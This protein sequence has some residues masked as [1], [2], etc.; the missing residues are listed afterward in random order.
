MKKIIKTFFLLFL[1][2]IL[3]LVKAFSQ[4]SIKLPNPQDK[5]ILVQTENFTIYSSASEQVAKNLG[6]KLERLKKTLTLL[7]SVK[8]V[9]SP[10]PTW[11][12]IFKDNKSFTPYIFDVYGKT[13]ELEGYFITH[14][15]GNYIAISAKN[16]GMRTIL[17]EYIHFFINNNMPEVPLWFNEGFAEYYSTFQSDGNFAQIGLPIRGHVEY[18]QSSSLMSLNELFS[19][20]QGSIFYSEETTQNIF[21]AQSWLLVHYLLRGK[22]G[23]LKP[24]LNQFLTRLKRGQSSDDAFQESFK[25]DYGSLLKDL[26]FYLRKGAFKYIRVSSTEISISPNVQIRP[27]AYEEVL[28]NLGDLVMHHRSK[29]IAEAEVHYQQAISLNPK[30]GLAFAGLGSIKLEQNNFQEALRYLETAVK[31]DPNNAAIQH[32]YA[33]CTMEANIKSRLR[34]SY[35]DPSI[36]NAV[37]EARGAFQKVIILDNKFYEAYVGFGETFLYDLDTPILPGIKAL[38]TAYINLPSRMDVAVNLL[39]LYAR[40]GDSLRVRALFET[41]IKK[42]ADART[43][44]LAQ[45]RLFQVELQKEVDHG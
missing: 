28:Y 34:I 14:D 33:I 16:Q 31:L 42:R 24:Q 23:T 4:E 15:E 30:Y 21:Y 45:K 8:N 1:F 38:E 17:H 26:K 18:L 6:I 9:N 32:K 10:V 35:S 29:K 19:I 5:W 43:I 40:N 27:L 13:P 12:Y 3:L 11:I 25:T 44:K 37:A 22:N 36:K 39:T 41:V 20:G 7:T 2:L